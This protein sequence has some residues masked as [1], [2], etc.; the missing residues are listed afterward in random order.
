MPLNTGEIMNALAIVS[1]H[2]HMNVAVKESAKGGII[3]GVSTV[4]G[5]LLLGPLGLALGGTFGGI[6]AYCMSKNKFK[7]VPKILMEDLTVRQKEELV[8]SVQ[9]VINDIR[10]E[11]AAVLASLILADRTLSVTV[12]QLVTNFLRTQIGAEVTGPSYLQ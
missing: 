1:E 3:T 8:R 5:G 9:A 7:P 6:T 12:L 11:D 2:E 10:A 4:C